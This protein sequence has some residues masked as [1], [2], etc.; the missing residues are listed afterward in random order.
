MQQ[1]KKTYVVD[2]NPPPYINNL[3]KYELSE[4]KN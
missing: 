2:N 4:Y 1:P 3:F